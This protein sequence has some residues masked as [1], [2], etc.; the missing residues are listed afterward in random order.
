[1]RALFVNEKFTQDSDPV[2]DLGIRFIQPG[3][4]L[5]CVKNHK[6]AIIGDWFFIY[7]YEI[8][9]ELLTLYVYP[10]AEKPHDYK[11]IAS[12][13]KNGTR[14]PY[15]VWV[16][17]IMAGDLLD[18]FK[19]IKNKTLLSESLNEKFTQDSDPVR[20]MNIGMMYL[21]EEFVKQNT[22]DEFQK[23][24]YCLT[25]PLSVNFKDPSY[26]LIVCCK[27]QHKIFTKYL[28]E[29]KSVNITTDNSLAFR[30]AC[31]WG[32]KQIINMF[33]ERGVNI[34]DRIDWD[35][36][37]ACAMFGKNM[38]IVKLLIER[39]AKIKSLTIEQLKDST[40]PQIYRYVRDYYIRTKSS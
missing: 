37:L 39:G 24:I 36:P 8:N 11:N 21:I 38:E 33:L 25:D 27:K 15:G 35:P 6:P 5:Y 31:H 3:D 19:I 26:M 40:T 1:M 14:L 29:Y 9:D 4:V 30:W 10:F 20:D 18:H 32:D 23:T 28:L 34:N 22:K 2:H 7:K 16:I 17:T 12:D 13:C